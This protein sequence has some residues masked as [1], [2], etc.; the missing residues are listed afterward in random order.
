M[1]VMFQIALVPKADRAFGARYA[2]GAP[3]G[4]LLT[5]GSISRPIFSDCVPCAEALTICD[6]HPDA[7]LRDWLRLPRHKHR[8]AAPMRVD[9]R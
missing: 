7:V 1:L 6:T 5:I 9:N 2:P 8:S 3:A 4:M